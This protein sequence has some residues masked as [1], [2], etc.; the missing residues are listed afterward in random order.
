MRIGA[1]V[2][3]AGRSTRFGQNKLLADAGGRPMVACAID[4]LTVAGGMELALVAG[5]PAVAAYAAKRG[6]RVIMNDQPEL[7]QAH[8]IALAAQAMRE[9]DALLLTAGDQPRLTGDSIRALVEAFCAS[10]KDI[11]CLQDET[12]F[13][14]PAIFSSAYFGELMALCGDRGAKRVIHAHMEDALLVPCVHA[15]EL[16]DADDPQTLRRIL[17]EGT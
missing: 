6:L 1:A 8:S 7:G 14:N 3:A 15:G 17:S 10:G 12:H 9:M 16:A 2:L 11:A 4:A 13:G 5:D